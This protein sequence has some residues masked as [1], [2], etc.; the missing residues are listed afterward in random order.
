MNQVAFVRELLKKLQNNDLALRNRFGFTALYSAAQS[1]ATEI[2]EMMIDRNPSLAQIPGNEGELPLLTA[3]MFGHKETASLLFE[4]TN[5]NII[6][7]EMLTKLFHNLIYS[8][9]FDFAVRL[10]DRTSTVAA[11]Q[12]SN[13][14]TAL[15]LMALK[16]Y[17]LSPNR[18]LSNFFRGERMSSSAGE[19]IENL[20]NHFVNQHGTFTSFT[21]PKIMLFDAASVGNAEFLAIIIS[22]FPDLIW[23]V[24]EKNQSIFHVAA[25]NRHEGVFGLIFD[26]GPAK[27][28]IL[29]LVDNTGCNILH[30]TARLPPYDRLQVVS[31]AAFQMQRELL[32]FEAVKKMVPPR[33]IESNTSVHN[34]PDVIFTEE[35]QALRKEGEKWLKGTSTTCMIVATLIA[36]L[37]FAASITVPSG[38]NKDGYPILADSKWFQTFYGASAV[39]F[40][41]SS[42]AIILF[43]S[44]L[45]SRNSS[46][47][48]R[49]MLPSSLMLGL[50]ML[51]VSIVAM[52]IAFCGAVI[53]MH[54]SKIAWRGGTLVCLALFIGISFIAMHLKL[55]VGMIRASYWSKFFLQHRSRRFL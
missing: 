33:C 17:A 28:R 47:E 54:H 37:V 27:S 3:I 46:N 4:R 49:M 53:V 51:F 26:L 21:Q 15:H 50:F 29:D 14:Y 34:T 39:A 2:V 48:F 25:E 42:L 38:F 12:D 40:I 22:K 35:H 32:W 16:P 19:L 11:S 31:G 55:L 43:M 1:G 36:T 8:D 10:L 20:W 45:T 44:I 52:V 13:G 18:M 30:L 41:C 23:F 9:F 24:N 6:N 7:N 5:F